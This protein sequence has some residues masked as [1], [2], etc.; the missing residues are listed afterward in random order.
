[1]ELAVDQRAEL[2]AVMNSADMS[3]TVVTRAQIVLWR[4][5]GRTFHGVAFVWRRSAA[6]AGSGA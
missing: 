5:E 3:P 4:A 2:R 1:M 6:T